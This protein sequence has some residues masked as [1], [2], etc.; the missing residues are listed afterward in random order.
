ME[1]VRTEGRK[2][3]KGKIGG[4]SGEKEQTWESSFMENQ[5]LKNQRIALFG[6][7]GFK[8]LVLWV[9]E[10]EEESV[11]VKRVKV[12]EKPAR[13]LTY[14]SGLTGDTVVISGILGRTFMLPHQRLP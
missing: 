6:S 13:L 4:I 10:L 7:K 12:F 14:L 8:T 1:G 2:R 5:N 11:V 3:P 9:E